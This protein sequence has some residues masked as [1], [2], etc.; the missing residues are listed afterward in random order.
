MIAHRQRRKRNIGNA[1]FTIV[2]LLI[3]VAIVGL[4]IAL[5]L[6]AI[7][8]A[9]EAARRVQCINHL[10]QIGIAT[11]SHVSTYGVFPT[12]GT[13]SFPR[14]WDYR[15]ASGRAYG[16]RK[17]GMGWMYQLLPFIERREVQDIDD[18]EAL[19]GVEIEIYFCPSRRGV[20]VHNDRALN[21][22]AAATPGDFPF[23][24]D[25]FW[26]PKATAVYRVPYGKKW[27]GVI[28]R[29]N[30]DIQADPPQA[31]NSTSPVEPRHIRDGLSK[32][33]MIGEKR[34]SIADYGGGY[35]NDDRGWS[36][37]WDTDTIRSTASGYGQDNHAHRGDYNFGSPHPHGMNALFAD[38]SVRTLSYD[39]D[40]QLF[41]SLADRRDGQRRHTE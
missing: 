31:A 27:N 21:D 22:Y 7:N 12:G 24:I 39:I 11:Q 40:L 1:A 5:L 34:Q 14:M 33:F 32:T 15:D 38:S 9:R 8:S 16:P 6:P 35:F 25:S 29:G 2:E 30:W 23:H 18:L 4:L 28:V 41:N 37:G 13:V 20:R 36:D 26:Q 19:M 10:R 3:V 17:Q